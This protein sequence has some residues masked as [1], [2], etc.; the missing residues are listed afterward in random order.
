MKKF[1]ILIIIIVLIIVF[2]PKKAGITYGGFVTTGMT[3]NRYESS[4]LGIKYKL[5]SSSPFGF[6]DSCSDCG[7]TIFCA[8]IPYGKKCYQAKYD[9]KTQLGERKQE[10]SCTN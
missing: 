8:G 5:T 10:V 9:G 7:R 4:C 3:L 2:Y 1:L 6:F